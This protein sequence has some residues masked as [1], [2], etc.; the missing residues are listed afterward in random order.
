METLPLADAKLKRAHTK[1]AITR[2]K[3]YIEKFDVNSGSQKVLIERKQRL[4]EL[5]SQFEAV[6]FRI[7][8]LE[9]ADPSIPDQRVLYEQH[10]QQRDRFEDSYFQL[11]ANYTLIES[12]ETNASL[13]TASNGQAERSR[14]T[15][16]KLPKIELPIFTGAYD[17][18]YSYRNTFEQ[19]IHLNEDL[20]YIE[21]FHYLR[22]SLK[23]AASDLIKSIET[24]AA[25]YHEA[26]AA[27]KERFD[28][29]R[30]IVQKHVSALFEVPAVRKEN[31]SMTRE[32]L[33]TVLKHLRALKALGRPTDYWNDLIIHLIIS[34]LPNSSNTSQSNT[35]AAG[36]ATDPPL[37]VATQC[38]SGHRSLNILLS[39]AIVHVYDTNNQIHSC[40]ALLD[41]GSQMNFI[42]KEL[43]NR[44][45]LRERPLD[46]SVA[47]VMD[48]II[49]ANKVVNLCIKS[50]FN[51]FS[52]KMDCAHHALI[53]KNINERKKSLLITITFGIYFSLLQ[54]IDNIN[55]PFTIADSIYGSTFFIATGFHG[56]YVI[57]GTLFLSVC[58]I[59]ATL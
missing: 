35:Q 13:S 34:K 17:D 2:L 11:M 40:R 54:L 24:T 55:S 25:N 57:I 52:E 16:V 8:I 43:A 5:C 37:P 15:R 46:V 33:D 49:H 48:E 31:H 10:A 7:E 19:L 50:R 44:L 36:Q 14:E 53:S 32:L 9:N 28:N 51:R 12:M 39:T 26:W 58:L 45:K 59:R 56:I 27:V 20:A 30:W 38:T 47:G 23:D 4:S 1:S 22:S 29:P 21:R 42:T 18:W 41:N 6:Q 3:T